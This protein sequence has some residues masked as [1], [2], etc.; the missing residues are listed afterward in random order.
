M[1]IQDVKRLHVPT[2]EHTPQKTQCWRVIFWSSSIRFS[3]I[4]EDAGHPSP[5][6]WTCSYTE[7]SCVVHWPWELQDFWASTGYFP[8]PKDG[9]QI[10]M[11]FCLYPGPRARLVD[12]SSCVF[13]HLLPLGKHQTQALK[14]WFLGRI[15]LRHCG[16]KAKNDTLGKEGGPERKC[17][18]L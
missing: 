7:D 11:G 16:P 9:S 8:L 17:M 3:H 6:L 12:V 2:D 14:T 5:G 15:P 13:I 18:H 10:G 1:Y 4:V